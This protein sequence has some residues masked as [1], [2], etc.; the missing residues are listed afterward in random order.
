MLDFDWNID[1]AGVAGQNINPLYTET[2]D[3]ISHLVEN[4]PAVDVCNPVPS[5]SLVALDGFSRLIGPAADMGA[6][7]F[8]TL[9]ISGFE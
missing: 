5:T 6:F 2:I 8:G 4:S 7:E 9:S 3:G 1:Q